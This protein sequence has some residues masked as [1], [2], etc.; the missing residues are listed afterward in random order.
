MHAHT[1]ARTHT[2]YVRTLHRERQTQ[3][4]RSHFHIKVCSFTTHVVNDTCIYFK[5]TR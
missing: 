4:V 1:H 5:F 3:R 2:A